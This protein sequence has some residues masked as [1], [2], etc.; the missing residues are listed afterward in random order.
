M[1]SLTGPFLALVSGYILYLLLARLL[2]LRRVLAL[3]RTAPSG[4]HLQY[5]HPQFLLAPVLRH[6]PQW[7][8]GDYRAKGTPYEKAGVSIIAATPLMAPEPNVWVSDPLA[9]KAVGGD[10]HLF[11]KQTELYD[12]I[13][14][15]GPN[16]V[17]T[18][19]DEWRRHRA[20]SKA[21][22]GEGNNML[23]WRESMRVV[24]EWFAAF[25]AQGGK[26]LGGKVVDA[27]DVMTE[28]ALLI[29]TSAGFGR[30]IPLSSA[31]PPTAS[32]KHSSQDLSTI[33]PGFKLP[34]VPALLTAVSGMNL[35]SL[36]TKYPLLKSL[37]VE[38]FQGTKLAYAELREYLRGMVEETR[39]EMRAEGEGQRAS[40]GEEADLF[41]LLIRANEDEEGLG[42]KLSD[43]ELLSTT[44]V[45]LLAGH[46]TTA[47]TLAFACALL[48][49]NPSVQAKLRAEADSV[50]PTLPSPEEAL[51]SYREDMPR[52]KYAEATFRE[53][54]R[55]FPAEVRLTKRAARDTVLRG[56]YLKTGEKYDMPV[57]AGTIV[58]LD[59]WAAHTMQEWWG[60]DAAEFKPERF[61]DT[62]EYKWPRDAYM[63]FSLGARSCI[64]AR[65]ATLE[66]MVI[67]SHLV[68][69]YEICL[70]PEME[71]LPL[72]ERKNQ[73]LSW[74]IGV[75][76]QAT[77]AKVMLKKRA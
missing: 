40:G 77:G 11:P 33:P 35:Q 67:L 63:P 72:E 36:M 2:A 20:A 8:V 68:R 9:L 32:S 62:D 74:A 58:W 46:E 14:F 54:L 23:V 70:T 10:R 31:Q 55:L 25:E 61:F 30:H 5:T 57:P 4:V 37:P 44:Y 49:L 64:G 48:A 19:G 45:F 6:Y 76:I 34:F 59:V 15:Y 42:Q 18:E 29:I 60:A 12:V 56:T 75:A 71:A 17:T 39:A 3:F 47:N 69:E 41:K 38:A 43:D 51:A 52:L 13:S 27:H 73:M 16:L 50:F 21:A 53:T 66:G 26:E 65:F 7:D 1:S 24:R 28:L 22:F